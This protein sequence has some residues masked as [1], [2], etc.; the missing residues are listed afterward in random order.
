V[1][2][3]IM[4][5]CWDGHDNAR[6]AGETGVGRHLDRA[7]WTPAQLGAAILDLLADGTMRERLAINAERMAQAPGTERAADAILKLL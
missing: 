1:P 4:P 5:Y 3:L 2:S 7:N 6:R